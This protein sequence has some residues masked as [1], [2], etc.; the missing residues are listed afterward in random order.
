MIKMGRVLAGFTILALVAGSLV[1]TGPATAA[2]PEPRAALGMLNGGADATLSDL[3]ATGTVSP[4]GPVFDRKVRYYQ[5]LAGAPEVNLAPTTTSGA[6]T[7]TIKL[8]GA[9]QTLKVDKSADL[10]LA[11]GRNEAVVTVTHL[12]ATLTYQVAMWLG[13]APVPTIVNITNPDSTVHGGSRT[14]VTVRDGT[15]PE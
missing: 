7:Y 10:V 5:L 1:G 2:V 14:T 3:V 8:N 9:A 15:L 11:R 12:T 13:M 4:L 6:A